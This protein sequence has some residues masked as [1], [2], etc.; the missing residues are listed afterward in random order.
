MVHLEFNV[1][2][3]GVGHLALTDLALTSLFLT[4][5][6]DGNKSTTDTE[7]CLKMINKVCLEFFDSYLKG[8]GEFTSGGT[9]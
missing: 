9:Y 6:L 2:I 5:V 3:S 8:A 1:Y 4:R 7:Y